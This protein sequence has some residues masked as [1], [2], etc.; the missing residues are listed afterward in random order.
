MNHMPFSLKSRY[1]SERMSDTKAP[2]P[3]AV[4]AVAEVAKVSTGKPSASAASPATKSLL[5]IIK[6]NFK[7]IALVFDKN[8]IETTAEIGHL[9]PVFL[10]FG[11]LFVSIITLNYPIFMLSASSAE[12]M[13]IYNLIY[14]TIG[15]A[16]SP[17]FGLNTDGAEQSQTCGSYF[18][19][20]TPSRFNYFISQGLRHEFPNQPLYFICFGAAYLIQSMVYMSEECS[21]LGPQYSTRTYLAILTAVMFI[22]L[23]MIYLNAYGC[24]SLSYLLFTA[25][26]GS[27][28]GY[29]I[30]VQNFL[31][32]GKSAVNVMFLPTL[33]RRSGMDYICVTTNTP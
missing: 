31:I 15:Y 26:I 28:V 20:I 4:E 27:L 30:S 2:A 24:D 11:S 23:Y 6:S 3:S 8:I 10:I 18:K 17:K 32:F 1:P 12:A 13:L 25:L 9:S 14:N 7:Q 33:G 16:I 29:L 22:V 19:K 21:E 5:E